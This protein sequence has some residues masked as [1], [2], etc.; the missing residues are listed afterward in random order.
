MTSPPPTAGPSANLSPAPLR[1]PA[2]QATLIAIDTLITLARKNHHPRIVAL[3]HVIKLRVLLR[4]GAWSQVGAALDM[5]EAILGLIFDNGKEN[6]VKEVVSA[7][8][9]AKA[10]DNVLPRWSSITAGDVHA[11]SREYSQVLISSNSNNFEIKPE[12]E[13][14]QSDPAHASLVIH[15]LLSG[16]I[17]F[18]F[19]GNIRAAEQRLVALHGL[20]DSGALQGFKDGVVQVRFAYLSLHFSS[21]F[22][23][24]G[25]RTLMLI[26]HPFYRSPS[27][28]TLP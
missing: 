13:S 18:T 27:H 14:T 24:F 4:A 8:G 21:L 17:F 7:K 11:L 23:T 26:I 3:A 20:V 6:N 5:A 2:L 12:E 1:A 28:R 22:P 25:P 10:E 9:A 19:S 16:A 15:T